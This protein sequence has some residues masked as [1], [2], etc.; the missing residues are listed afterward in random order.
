VAITAV[1]TDE[2]EFSVN[3]KSLGRIDALPLTNGRMEA[4]DGLDGIEGVSSSAFMDSL[5]VAISRKEDRSELGKDEISRLTESEK[6]EFAAKFLERNQYLLPEDNT[7]HPRAEDESDS[8][9]LF[10]LFKDDQAKQQE[11]MRQL[12]GP[13]KN[14]LEAHKNLF[15]PS[16]LEAFKNSQSSVAQLQDLAKRLGGNIPDL[17]KLGVATSVDALARP[18]P[19]ERLRPHVPDF[20]AIRHPSQ[21]TNERL[22]EVVDHLDQMGVLAV[23][24][25]KTVGDVSKTVSELLITLGAASDKSDRASRRAMKIAI[26]ALMV[27]VLS[28]LVQIVYSEWRTHQDQ[29]ATN[30]VVTEVADRIDSVVEAQR[31]SAKRLSNALENSNEAIASSLDRLPEAMGALSGSLHSQ[32]TIPPKGRP[33]VEGQN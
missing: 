2:P 6:N 31:D 30:A 12:I 14:A 22:S 19:I 9:F 13:F 7:K 27:A 20:S 21:D 8:E 23:Q 33:S 4:L 11:R 15:T 5:I 18:A 25:A 17:S 29:T 10:R 28:P 16:F 32:E 1:N 26:S 24:T 3:T